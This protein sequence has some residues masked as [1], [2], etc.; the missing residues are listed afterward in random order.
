MNLNYLKTFQVVCL[1]KSLSKAAKELGYTQANVSIQLKKVEEEFGVKLFEKVGYSFELTK[2][3]EELLHFANQI[4][5]DYHCFKTKL[6]MKTNNRFVIGA[7]ESIAA[8]YLP[9]YIQKLVQR[10]PN[11]NVEIQTVNEDTLKHFVLEG[12]IDVAI[13]LDQW[14]PEASDINIPIKEES[15]V[16]IAPPDHPLSRIDALEIRHLHGHRIIM[17]EESCVYRK[18]LEQVLYHND[19]QFD[20]IFSNVEAIKKCVMNGLGISILPSMTIS[21]ERE[22]GILM[23]IPIHHPILRMQVRLAINHNHAF[24]SHVNDLKQILTEEV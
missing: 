13:L 11:L 7:T 8:Y 23:A 19:I 2:Q 12:S 22:R 24:I 20:L 9:P 15:L 3:G 21:E 18:L 10:H 4:L 1:Y 14:T 17:T 6:T 16:L 5:N